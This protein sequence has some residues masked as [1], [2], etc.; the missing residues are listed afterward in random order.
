MIYLHPEG[1]STDAAPG[2][3]IEKL[4]K[5]GF[6]VVAA[7]VIG[8]GETGN[9]SGS[10]AFT[11][12]L[13]GRSIPGVQAGDI[14]RVAKF[15]RWLGS[16]RISA[17]AFGELCPALLHAAAFDSSIEKI[18]LVDFPVSYRSI[19][20]NRFY[21][22]SFSCA[23]AG[24][25]T[26]YDLPDLAASVAP[27]KLLLIEPKNQLKETASGELVS[28]ELEFPRLVYKKK[29]AGHYLKILPVKPENCMEQIAG[30]LE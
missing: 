24:A 3:K 26:A 22:W 15:A 25:L 13:V 19:V 11:A 18:T 14:V 27:R 30:W 2:G 21:E 4:V 12:M 6:T 1:N 28:R 20:M 29:D 23:V 5:R 7:D 16:S 17:L 10:A 9:G 8:T